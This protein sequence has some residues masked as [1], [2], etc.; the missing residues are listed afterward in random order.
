VSQGKTTRAKAGTNFAASVAS[1]LVARPTDLL[2]LVL[3]GND[4]FP[5]FGE[6]QRIQ[7]FIRIYD[8]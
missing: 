8:C 1:R 7:S 3:N 2:L 5:K 4:Y 6:P